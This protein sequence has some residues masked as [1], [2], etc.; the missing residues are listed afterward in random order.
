MHSIPVLPQQR[1]LVSRLGNG[2]TGTT[3]ISNYFHLSCLCKYKADAEVVC[4]MVFSFITKRLAH[5]MN[6]QSQDSAPYWQNVSVTARKG[7]YPGWAQLL[8]QD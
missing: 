8:K 5:T 4:A 6:I 3:A 7:L 1:E 2:A